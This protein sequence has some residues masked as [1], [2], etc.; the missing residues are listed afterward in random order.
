MSVLARIRSALAGLRALVRARTEDAALD[1]ELAAF[2]E[3]AAADRIARGADPAS[4]RRDAR[5]A[6]GNPVVVKEE[7]RAAGWEHVVET[8]AQDARYSARALRRT[9]GFTAIVVLTLGL[10]IGGNAAILGLINTLYFAR[11]PIP[12]PDRVLRLN[13][14]APGPGGERRL[15]GMHSQNV[16]AAFEQTRLFS[17]AVAMFG[18][19]VTITGGGE[20]ERV[21]AVSRTFGWRDT[22]GVVPALGRDFTI[23]EERR[24]ASSGVAL[25]SDALWKRRFAGESP[26]TS[27]LHLDG[28]PVVVIGVMPP[29]FRFPYEADVWIPHVLNPA[30][31]ARDYAVF[32]RMEDGIALPDARAALDVLSANLRSKYPDELPGYAASARMLRD[33]LVDNQAGTS[34]ALLSLVGFLLVLACVNVATLLLARSAAR[35]K[36]ITVRA[37]LGA[38]RLRQARQALTEALLLCAFGAGAGLAFAAWLAPITSML[39]PSNISVQLGGASPPMDWRVLSVTA[40]LSVVVAACCAVLPMA[41]SSRG[42]SLTLREGGRGSASDSPRTRLALNV[43]VAGQVVLAIVLLSGAAAMIE[44]LAA[45]QR[46]DLGVKT[47]GL[48]TLTVTPSPTAYSDAPRRAALARRM[49]DQ[50]SAIPGVT[51]AG[52][53]TVN[54]LGGA[55]WGATVVREGGDPARPSDAVQIN[56][57]LVTPGTFRA[58]GIRLLRGRDVA[59]SDAAGQAPIAIVSER[60]ARQLWPGRDAVGKRLRTAR[61]TSWLTVAG[62]VTDVA[63]ARD[64]GDPDLTWY[65]PLMQHAG[66]PAATDL[67]LMLRAPETVLPDVR[68]QL[69]RIDPMLAAYDIAAMDDYYARTLDRDRVGAVLITLFGAFGLLLAALGVYGVASFAVAQRT[70]E[71]GIRMALGATRRAIVSFVFARAWRLAMAAAAVGCGGAFAMRRVIASILP[72]V[73]PSAIAPALGSAAALLVVLALACYLPARRAARVDPLEALRR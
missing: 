31:H 39:I 58:M 16:A 19:D 4:A 62:V 50:L 48:V 33:N 10:G 54:P 47:T 17:S 8:V 20:P 34:L 71:I 26:G 14:S 68:R 65:L 9:P 45:L 30:D 25:V 72:A 64:P 6:L 73:E 3:A 51:A 44:N 69:A 36:E 55:N 5:L 42:M 41:A 40:V 13:D 53:T 43:L 21:T 15:F 32:A 2:Y 1:D 29:G 35:R 22:L 27:V 66:T 12:E 57:R 38:S 63:D 46:R 70:S 52:L 37:V 23:D 61:G 56:H 60:L 7:T 49:V 28:R 18:Q 11:L 24:G 59:W 67:H